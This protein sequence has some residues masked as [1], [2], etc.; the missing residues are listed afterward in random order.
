MSSLSPLDARGYSGRLRRSLP[1]LLAIAVAGL[2]TVLRAS[3]GSPAESGPIAIRWVSY[4]SGA[5]GL[6]VIE[7]AGLL[8][9]AK[10]DGQHVLVQLDTGA[11]HTVFYRQV[12]DHLGIE[13]SLG[14]LDRKD[15]RGVVYYGTVPSIQLGNRVYRNVAVKIWDV[16]N[17]DASAMESRAIKAGNIGSSLFKD[18]VLFLDFANDQVS[19][20]NSVPDVDDGYK[21]PIKLVGSLPV[22]SGTLGSQELTMLYDTGCSAWPLIVTT[23]LF[24]SMFGD[25]ALVRS[26]FR[27]EATSWGKRVCLLGMK[28]D[29]SLEV[30][31]ATFPLKT[32]WGSELVDQLEEA[33]GINAII[34]NDLFAGARVYIDFPGQRIVIEPSR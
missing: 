3:C 28:T 31:G 1:I 7:K 15:P 24:E 18:S 14:K 25:E 2:L 17:L 26:D 23:S 20:L 29:M 9:E 13:Y 10:L 16:P 6:R 8:I 34:G 4:G 5:E 12:L 22:F 21:V 30:G 19:I 11:T 33:L 27:L 32:V